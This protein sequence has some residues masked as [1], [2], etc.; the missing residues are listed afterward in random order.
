[1]RRWDRLLDL[2]MEEYRA[3]R[4]NA[5]TMECTKCGRRERNVLDGFTLKH[6]MPRIA[7][8]SL[9][10]EE[11]ERLVQAISA[12]EPATRRGRPVV[13]RLYGCGLRIEGSV[14][15]IWLRSNRERHELL[16]LPHQG[17]Q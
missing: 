3:R 5:A 16:V 17:R 1:M 8:K 2:Y 6:P 11:A 7:P 12:T 14:R 15:R 9:S 10:L 4:V 13:L